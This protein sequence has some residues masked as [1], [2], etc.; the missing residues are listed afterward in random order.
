MR[1]VVQIDRLGQHKVE[2]EPPTLFRPAGVFVDGSPADKGKR[3]GQFVLRCDDGDEAFV[4]VKPSLFYDAPQLQIDGTTIQV[5]EPLPWYQYLVS[6]IPIVLTFGGLLG[7]AIAF[8]LI[9]ANV[10]VFRSQLSQPQKYL[11]VTGLSVG[12]PVL[13]FLIF[14]GVAFLADQG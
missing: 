8:L 13:Y 2:V 1:H 9:G 6:S 3:R 10:R 12:V 5:V 14:F 4:M 11:I 7:L